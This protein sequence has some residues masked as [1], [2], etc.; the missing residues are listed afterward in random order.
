[1]KLP[2]EK[3]KRR[4]VSKK[5]RIEKEKRRIVPSKRRQDDWK[6][7]IINFRHS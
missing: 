7:R 5:W 2:Q 6:R 3:V 4:G 1:V